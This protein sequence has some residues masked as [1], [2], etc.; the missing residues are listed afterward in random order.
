MNMSAA[1]RTD[2]TSY[3]FFDNLPDLMTIEE[4]ARFLQVRPKTVRNWIG[5]RT[6]PYV[7]GV[8]RQNM[9]K[10]DSLAAWLNKKEVK[11][12]QSRR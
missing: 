6:F 12:W 2:N 7:E 5:A 8:G 1:E 11:P 4:V 3:R 9:V 10:K